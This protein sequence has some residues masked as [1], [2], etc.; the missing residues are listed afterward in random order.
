MKKYSFPKET[1]F[2]LFWMQPFY[3][4]ANK[5]HCNVMRSF[6]L[7]DDV[8][9]GQPGGSCKSEESTLVSSRSYPV[10]EVTPDGNVAQVEIEGGDLPSL[11]GKNWILWKKSLYTKVTMINIS[12]PFRSRIFLYLFEKR[13]RTLRA[14]RRWNTIANQS[15]HSSPANLVD[16]YFPCHFTMPF[17]PVFW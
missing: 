6:C 11:A 14:S 9:V 1:I 13:G 17:W 12:C 16:G 7:N 15:S 2:N 8:F 4:K 5:N 10:K 3:I